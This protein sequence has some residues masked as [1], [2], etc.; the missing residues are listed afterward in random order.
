MSWKTSF[1]KNVSLT[2]VKREERLFVTVY[3]LEA[4]PDVP[5]IEVGIF[6]HKYTTVKPGQK[7][8]HDQYRLTIILSNECKDEKINIGSLTS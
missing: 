1:N 8:S 5:A 3:L 7:Q 6:D 4:E 2:K